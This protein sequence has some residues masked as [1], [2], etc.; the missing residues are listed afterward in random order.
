[1]KTVDEAKEYARSI[2]YSGDGARVKK[3][4]VVD[5]DNGDIVLKNHE[6]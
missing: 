2:K 6:I 3:A 4:Q 1:M 5:L